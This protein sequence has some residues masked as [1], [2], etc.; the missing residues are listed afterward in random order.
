MVSQLDWEPGVRVA[1]LGPGTGAIT[2]EIL[3]RLPAEGRYLGIDSDAAFAAGLR[4]RW[5]HV[6][7]VCG[8]AERLAEVTA[9]RGLL[10][11][12][13]IVSGL[14]FASLPAS[15]TRVVLGAIEDTLRVGGTFTTFQYWHALWLPSA[16][17]F[18][19]EMT[20]RMGAAPTM[21]TVVRNV[22]PAV[23]VQWRR[24]APGGSARSDT[25]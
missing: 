6:D 12:D 5:P 22:P 21:T 16:V 14:P 13:H 9:A 18:R 3:K 20:S 23:V 8:G 19:N 11:L 7:W 15:T 2:V 10:G 4:V 24:V 25:R 1:E 17:A